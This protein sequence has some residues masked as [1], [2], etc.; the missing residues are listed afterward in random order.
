MAGGALSVR[1]AMKPILRLI[2]PFLTLIT[3]C[4]SM[5]KESISTSPHVDL[6][7]FMGRWYVIASIPTFV[8]RKAFG[9]SESYAQNP[10]GT[11]ATTF[12]F[13]QGSLDGPVKTMKPKAFLQSPSNATWAMQF[14][15]PFKAEYLIAYVDPDYSETIIA[16]NKRDYV[17]IMARTPQ[18]TPERYQHLVD[19]VG[20]L[21][22]DLSKLRR[23][24]QGSDD[25]GTT[26]N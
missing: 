21:G 12:T 3:A 4:T 24:P 19:A 10:D 15:W 6:P 25:R 20:V 16:R 2:L 11:I 14:L 26:V 9:A 7:R 5:P 1:A 22:Y 23:V 8:E 18:L 17:W 13:H